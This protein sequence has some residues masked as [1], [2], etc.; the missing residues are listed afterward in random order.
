MQTTTEGKK[1]SESGTFCVSREVKMV[2]L[3]KSMLLEE[4]KKAEQASASK[5]ATDQNRRRNPGVK[6][7]QIANRI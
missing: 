7:S 5:R 4:T 1:T 3:K 2:A 6:R